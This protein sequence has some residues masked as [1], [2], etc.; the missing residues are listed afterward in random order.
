MVNLASFWS[1]LTTKATQTKSVIYTQMTPQCNNFPD[2]EISVQS[3]KKIRLVS[4]SRLQ[5][6]LEKRIRPTANRIPLGLRPSCCPSLV[7]LG[8]ETRFCCTEPSLVWMH[9]FYLFWPC[10][11]VLGGF[12]AKMWGGKERDCVLGQE[13]PKQSKASLHC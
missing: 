9:L 5:G 4:K 12:N 8:G 3:D 6:S 13:I 10:F 2:N 11:T 7:V 1:P